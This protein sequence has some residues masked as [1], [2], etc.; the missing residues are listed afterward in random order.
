MSDELKLEL[1]FNPESEGT[2]SAAESLA[3]SLNAENQAIRSHTEHADV[4]VLYSSGYDLSAPMP[5]EIVDVSIQVGSGITLGVLANILYDYISENNDI[6]YIIAEGVEINVEGIDE[7]DL[8][9]NIDEAWS[10]EK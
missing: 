1:I 3:S 2:A 10:E 5:T 7:K 6:E 9:S 4:S 8:K